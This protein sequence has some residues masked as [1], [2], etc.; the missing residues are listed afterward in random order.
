MKNYLALIGFLFFPCIIC[1]QTADT[2]SFL[3]DVFSNRPVYAHAEFSSLVGQSISITNVNFGFDGEIRIGEHSGFETRYSKGRHRMQYLNIGVGYKNYGSNTE[4]SFPFIIGF[5]FKN[6]IYS[7]FIGGF[8]FQFNSSLCEKT[9]NYYSNTDVTWL[10]VGIEG[11]YDFFSD[12]EDVCLTPVICG[13]FGLVTYK[14]DTLIFND[15]PNDCKK[16]QYEWFRGKLK[17]YGTYKS[18][19]LTIETGVRGF[20]DLYRHW[21]SGEISYTFWKENQTTN[22]LGRPEKYHQN[23]FRAFVSFNS[24]AF[25]IDKTK[26]NKQTEVVYERTV[27][28]LRIGISG[29][30]G[31]IL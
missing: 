28:S 13:S 11:G 6:E 23:N 7:E 30:I 5:L 25:E 2:S 4:Q 29:R 20:S 9:T 19:D 21:F 1:A 10:D 16:L 24:N 15:L 22:I 26:E 17:L 31:K 8:A 3:S 12:N 18:F 14:P 27:Q